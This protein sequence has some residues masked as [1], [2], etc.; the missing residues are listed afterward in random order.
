MR[1]PAVDVLIRLDRLEPP[2]G[3]VV[4]HPHGSDTQ[5]EAALP[6][7]GWLGLLRVLADV[8]RSAEPAGG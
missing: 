3:T 7:V 4:A 5:A 8:L 1:L 2:R 6:F